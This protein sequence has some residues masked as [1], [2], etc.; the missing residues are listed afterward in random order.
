MDHVQSCLCPLHTW[1]EVNC[2][3]ECRSHREGGAGKQ[4]WAVLWSA[5]SPTQT[6]SAELGPSLLYPGIGHWREGQYPP[7][8]CTKAFR[9]SLKFHQP[10]HYWRFCP[11]N[12]LLGALPLTVGCSA[13]FLAACRGA[14]SISH[15]Q[16]WQQ[17]ISSDIATCLQRAKSSPVDYHCPRQCQPV[18][19]Q[20]PETHALA[21]IEWLISLTP[22]T[23]T[24]F[25]SIFILFPHKYLLFASI[26]INTL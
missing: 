1:E 3:S 6:T 8:S 21:A 18:S 9:H 26:L 13:T 24:I 16:V 7:L 14:G 2:G 17:K 25:I 20:H 19:H 22:R 23:V 15:P 10:R 4:G 11:D 12:S 5:P